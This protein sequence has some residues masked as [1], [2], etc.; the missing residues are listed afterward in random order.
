M[1]ESKFLSHQQIN[2]VLNHSYRAP[3]FLTK[4]DLVGVV[5]T[6]GKVKEGSLDRGIA[7]LQSWGLHI[8]WGKA[9]FQ[10]DGYFAGTDQARKTDLQ[11]MLD[12]PEIKAVFCARGGYGTT[13]ILDQLSFDTFLTQPKWLIGFSDI[14][15]LHA[16]LHTLHIQSIHGSTISGFRDSAATES[17]RKLLFGENVVVEAPSCTD[18][19]LG[20]AEGLLIG[21]NVS[22]L[23]HLLGTA[24]AFQTDQKILFIEEIGEALYHFDRMMI[25]LN[26]AGM[27]NNLAGLIVGGMTNMCNPD[28]KFKLSIAEIILEKAQ[29][30]NYPIA[31][32][33]PIGH[34]ENNWAMPC[35]KQVKLSVREGER[36][37]L[38]M[39]YK[40]I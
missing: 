10:Q 32:N 18:N 15:A 31:F 12:N 29:Q 14:T 23:C 2:I 13:R 19:V 4:G 40:S 17:I 33:F 25:Q 27:L 9:V 3:A 36:S 7:L 6:A 11:S 8:V 20:E 1:E 5:A 28:H 34:I 39:S 16:H 38:K 22:L 26:R 35:G 30:H 24:S 21:G 37:Q